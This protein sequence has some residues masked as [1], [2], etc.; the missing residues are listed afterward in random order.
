[1]FKFYNSVPMIWY[2]REMVKKR[3]IWKRKNIIGGREREET[4]M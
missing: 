4:R 3:I 1:M 2:M